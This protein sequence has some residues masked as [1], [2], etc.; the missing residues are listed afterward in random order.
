[1][2]EAAHSGLPVD[3]AQV[4]AA[5]GSEENFEMVTGADCSDPDKP[6]GDREEMYQKLEQELIQMIRVRKSRL[7]LIS[8]GPLKFCLKIITCNLWLDYFKF[9]LVNLFSS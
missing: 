3:M 4:P 7:K 2:I 5:P 1:M 6:V 9:N 8:F